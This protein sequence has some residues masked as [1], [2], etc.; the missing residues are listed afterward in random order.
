[1]ISP[2]AEP[3]K[4]ALIFPAGV[5]PMQAAAA[6]VAIGYGA[7]QLAKKIHDK[8]KSLGEDESLSATWVVKEVTITLA[9]TTLTFLT[10]G[11]ADAVPDVFG[12]ASEISKLVTESTHIATADGVHFG[13]NAQNINVGSVADVAALIANLAEGKTPFKMTKYRN[14]GTISD[15]LAKDPLKVGELVSAGTVKAVQPPQAGANNGFALL[16]EDPDDLMTI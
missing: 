5:A 11:L 13:E 16:G 1:M 2:L 6:A 10:G 4:P 8:S 14:I 3:P 9:A 15:V 7:Y 12:F